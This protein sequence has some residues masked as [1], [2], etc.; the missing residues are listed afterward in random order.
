MN[1]T[2]SSWEGFV[3]LRFQA[4][5]G[6]GWSDLVLAKDRCTKQPVGPSSVAAPRTIAAA[7]STGSILVSPTREIRANEPA[8]GTR[9]ASVPIIRSLARTV[10]RYCT[11]VSFVDGL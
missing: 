5:T 9:R 10:C 1:V 2:E 4:P 3:Q 6:V 11:R 8:L 7:M